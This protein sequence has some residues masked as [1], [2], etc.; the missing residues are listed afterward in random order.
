MS[1]HCLTVLTSRSP[2][3][4]ALR[5][6]NAGRL[7]FAQRKSVN[8][9]KHDVVA[10]NKWIDAAFSPAIEIEAD[11]AYPLYPITHNHQSLTC[12]LEIKVYSHVFSFIP[13]I[14]KVFVW[15]REGGFMITL[16]LKFLANYGRNS[17]SNHLKLPMSENR[18]RFLS[19]YKLISM[20]RLWGAILEWLR[21]S[22]RIPSSPLPGK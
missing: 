18:Q 9:M 1:T 15:R 20:P 4:H 21:S 17:L 13:V 6:M 11:L 10:N 12:G 16:E 14:Y 5:N 19:F 2:S 8:A 3:H 22:V 7:I